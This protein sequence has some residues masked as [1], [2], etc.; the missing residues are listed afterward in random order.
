MKTLLVFVI[1]CSALAAGIYFII[2]VFKYVEDGS[3]DQNR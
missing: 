2:N 3:N 1:A